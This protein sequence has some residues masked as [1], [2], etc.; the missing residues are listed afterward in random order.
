M[1][2]PVHSRIPPSLADCF[3]LAALASNPASV[4]RKRIAPNEFKM[5]PS[6][7]VAI[8]EGLL[9]LWRSLVGSGEEYHFAV[10]GLPPNPTLTDGDPAETR[11]AASFG[12]GRQRIYGLSDNLSE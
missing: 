4:S 7:G 3:N 11:A 6:F 9:Q 5:V 12:L 8:L 10:S 2:F 1:H